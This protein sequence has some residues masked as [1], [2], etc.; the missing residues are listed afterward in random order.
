MQ[1]YLQELRS[2]QA[3]VVGRMLSTM[4]QMWERL[5]P[6]QNRPGVGGIYTLEEL[7][8]LA[9]QLNLEFTPP[10]PEFAPKEWRFREWRIDIEFMVRDGS[11]TGIRSIAIPLEVLLGVRR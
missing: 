4:E 10:E 7:F 1:A 11:G 8:A 5:Y 9:E 3:Q 2:L 6:E